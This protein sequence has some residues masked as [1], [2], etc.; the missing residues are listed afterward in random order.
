PPLDRLAAAEHEAGLV[1]GRHFTQWMD[2]VARLKREGRH[3]EAL[4]LVREIIEATEREQDVERA[5]VP[6]RARLLG[7]PA[8]ELV[9]RETP[10]AWT[11]QAAIILRKLRDYEGEVAAIDRWIVR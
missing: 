8:S 4:E 5:H 9:V 10:P 6:E 1:R 2:E 3:S 11:E 7:R